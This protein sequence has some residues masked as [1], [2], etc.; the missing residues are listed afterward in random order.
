M[1]KRGYT[2]LVLRTKT[3]LGLFNSVKIYGLET[4]T[5]LIMEVNFEK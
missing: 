2:G 4:C 5:V 3:K 1:S